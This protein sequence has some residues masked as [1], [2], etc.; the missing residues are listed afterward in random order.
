[1]QKFWLWQ[2]GTQY[3]LG[4]E[5]LNGRS[6]DQIWEALKLRKPLL[7]SFS[8]YRMFK[9]QEEVSWENLPVL[10]MVLVPKEIPVLNRGLEFKIS[11]HRKTQRLRTV[12]PLTQMSYQI[13]TIEKTPLGEPV[14]IHAPNEI[15]LAQLV[16]FFILPTGTQLDVG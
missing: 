5:E 13:F 14:V 11:D 1:M 15:A 6:R 2:A 3:D 10:D 16:T 8:D 7:K 12:G 4:S 9:G